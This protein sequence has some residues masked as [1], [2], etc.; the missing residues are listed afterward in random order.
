MVQRC[1]QGQ[2]AA[3]NNIGTGTVSGIISNYKAQLDDSE[4]D[5]IRGLAIEIR[6]QELHFSDLAAHIRLYNFFE[7]SGISEDQIERFI[8]IVHLSGI[9]QRKVVEYV[10]QLYEI[11]REQSIALEHVPIYVKRKLEEKQNIDQGIKEADDVL[12]TKNV[13][14]HAIAEYQTLKEELDAHRVSIQGIDN[15]LNLLSNAKENGFDSKKIVKELGSVERLVK[16]KNKAKKNYEMYSK[17]LQKCKDVLPLTEEIA[18]LG[19]GVDELIAF[20]AAINQGAKLYNL[21]P[22]AATLRLVDEIRKYNMIG[23]LENELQRLGL[24]K[25]AITEACACQSLALAKM[26]NQPNL[27]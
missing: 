9:P 18:A 7:E 4:F 11:S 23:G 10:N 17:L 14:I 16:R 2:S 24:Q 5:S 25:F 8:Q 22:L 21:P 6:K 26:Q 1:F 19:I 13:N 12:Q 27:H 20:K 15:L 3:D